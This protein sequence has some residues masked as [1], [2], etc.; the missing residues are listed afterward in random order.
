V[1]HHIKESGA[2]SSVNA[3]ISE[4]VIRKTEPNLVKIP[5]GLK[6]LA[7]QYGITQKKYQELVPDLSD[8]ECKILIDK[9]NS[10]YPALSKFK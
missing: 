10:L 6:N 9:F 8:A 7:T 4:C 3:K 1:S 2:G 5:R